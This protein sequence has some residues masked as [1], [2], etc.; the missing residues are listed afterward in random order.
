MEGYIKLYRKLLESPIFQNEKALK[1]WIWCLCKAT[2]KEIDVLVG[3]QMVH[4]KSGQFVFGRKKASK[5]LKLNESTIYKY[6]Q[7][8]QDMLMVHLESNTKFTVVTIEKW[9]EYQIEEFKNNMLQKQRGNN[10]RTQTRM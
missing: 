2:H 6:M 1:I 4:L 9:Q 7:L 5:E 10:K 3:Q 8:L